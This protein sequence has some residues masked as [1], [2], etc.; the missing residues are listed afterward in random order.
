MTET[1]LTAVNDNPGGATEI[2]IA[3]IGLVEL[4]ARAEA[5]R[6]A[7]GVVVGAVDHDAPANTPQAPT[8]RK[9]R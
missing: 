7:G 4:L 1:L 9:P 5:R 3:L 2:H 6:L 8:K